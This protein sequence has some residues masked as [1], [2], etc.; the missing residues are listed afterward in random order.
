M[1]GSIASNT[2]GSFKQNNWLIHIIKITLH[3]YQWRSC[4]CVQI[5][6]SSNEYF[7][8]YGKLSF[9]ICKKNGYK[10]IISFVP[11]LL[12]LEIVQTFAITVISI[13]LRNNSICC[14][15]ELSIP[16]ISAQCPC[17]I[18]QHV[19][20]LIPIELNVWSMIKTKPL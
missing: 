1:Y 10:L 14:L 20:V 17:I 16:N 2:L 6:G 7:I 9:W 4:L 12:N 5:K 18:S 13:E 3:A 8:T 15:I 11:N 19:F